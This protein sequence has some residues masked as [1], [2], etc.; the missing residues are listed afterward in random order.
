M[1]KNAKDHAILVS[2][3]TSIS[4]MGIAYFVPE[5]VQ[6]LVFGIGLIMFCITVAIMV[7]E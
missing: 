6:T 2:L 5:Y 1:N 3:A 7:A 4:F